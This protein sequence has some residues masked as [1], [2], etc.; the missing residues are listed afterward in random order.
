M[1]QLQ[2]DHAERDSLLEETRKREGECQA[3]RI[4]LQQL[5]L[6]LA[7]AEKP[8]KQQISSLAETLMESSPDEFVSIYL[9]AAAKAP[10]AE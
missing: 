5:V 1:D 3:Q 6:E 8:D 10:K 9:E 4:R 7:K 2:R